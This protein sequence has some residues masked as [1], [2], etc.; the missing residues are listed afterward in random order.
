M[1]VKNTGTEQLIKDTA[2]RL[3]FAE[4]RLHA[5]TQEIADAAGVSRTALHYYYRSRDLLISAVFQEAM[6]ALSK[7][8]DHC[9]ESNLPF[10]DKVEQLIS[11]FME[12]MVAFPY[13]ETFL[14]TEINTLGKTLIESIENGP[15][16][17]F[18][19]EVSQE[20]EHGTIL[21]M[22]PINFLINLFS[23]L[24]YP[25]IM[26]PLYREM[27]HIDE[28]GFKKLIYDRKEMILKM[29]FS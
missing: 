5:T 17:Q 28:Q 20:I 21:K 27:F 6:S 12:D 18:L 14:V 15:V 19:M 23:L 8:L 10:R 1:P 2:K 24:S 26:A 4:G 16:Q 22:E 9:L 7:R 3:F 13:Q 29:I 11:V 25:L